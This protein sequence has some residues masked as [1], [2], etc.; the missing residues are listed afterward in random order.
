MP[1]YAAGHLG[2][3]LTLTAS[4]NLIRGRE[5]TE[6]ALKCHK[7]HGEA[8]IRPLDLDLF[9]Y[10]TSCIL[11]SS[12]AAELPLKSI[13][14]D[15]ADLLL[16]AGEMLIRLDFL[17]EARGLIEPLE[18]ILAANPMARTHM[19]FAQLG[20]TTGDFEAAEFH[21][22]EAVQLSAGDEK[23]NKEARTQLAATIHL[24]HT[25]S[26]NRKQWVNPCI[27][28]NRFNA[29]QV[30]SAHYPGISVLFTNDLD[31]GGRR[32]MKDYLD[33]VKERYGHVED[34]FEWCTGPGFL[35]YAML[36][37]GFTDRL[38]LADINPKAVY[39]AQKTRAANCLEDKVDIYLSDN[40]D[41]IPESQQWDLVISNPPHYGG[42]SDFFTEIDRRSLDRDWQIHRR[43]FE[44]VGAHLK[45]GGE[46]CILE[47]QDQNVPDSSTP[48]L[49]QPM[50]EENGFVMIDAVTCKE[51]ADHYYLIARK[52]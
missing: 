46:L 4:G 12:L 35:G 16:A 8:I 9:Q 30:F 24:K 21:A 39:F 50:L 45:P 49:F 41:Q 34:L 13:E 20:K 14:N 26:Y 48:E 40:L 37:H 52:K 19:L 38:C 47:W 44:Q 51:V 1:D 5:L 28:E 25:A 42:K 2:F 11:A 22:R 33:F 18:P 31:G 17:T 32:L 15:N 3:G 10:E 36:A 6:K 43:F 7:Q 29:N 27:N 23:T